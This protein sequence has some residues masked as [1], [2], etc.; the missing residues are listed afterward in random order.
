MM[1]QMQWKYDPSKFEDEMCD[2]DWIAE[3]IAASNYTPQTSIENLAIMVCLCYEG[4]LED[5]NRTSYLDREDTR[6]YPENLM[7]DRTDVA[8]FVRDNGGLKEFD[9][10]A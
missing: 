1:D 3:Y 8:W 2:L 5:N 9:Y 10:E 4:W 6:P 7:I